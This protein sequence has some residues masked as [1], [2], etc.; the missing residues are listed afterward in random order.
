MPEREPPFEPEISRQVPVDE[1]TASKPEKRLRGEID[2]RFLQDQFNLP[3]EQWDEKFRQ[4]IQEKAE[5]NQRAIEETERELAGEVLETSQE[6]I[7]ESPEVIRE[8]TFERYTNG[9][10]LDGGE[11]IE[12][13]IKENVTQEAYGLD[14][15]PDKLPI[16][17]DLKNHIFEGNFQKELPIKNLDYVVSLGTVSNAIWGGEEVQDIEGIIKNSLAALK[18]GGE[19]RIYPIQEATENS[20]LEGTKE[21]HKKWIH[22]LEKISKTEGVEYSINPRTVK[23]VGKNNDI[24][25]ESVL[26]IKNELGK[27]AKW[28]KIV[29]DI[30]STTDGLGK[31]IEKDIKDTVIGLNALGIGTYQS[32]HGHVN[33][34]R[35]SPWVAINA[36][37]APEPRFLPREEIT[38]GVYEKYGISENLWK[39]QEAVTGEW[40]QEEAKLQ[41]LGDSEYRKAVDELRE[42]LFKKHGFTEDDVEKFNQLSKDHDLKET[43]EYEA[44]SE[45]NKKLHARVGKLLEEFYKEREVPENVRILLAEYFEGN[46]FNIYSGKEDYG[47]E[48]RKKISDKEKRELTKRLKLY[49]AEFKEFAEF[50][51]DKFFES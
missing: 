23:V 40:K 22:L 27:E 11:F 26:V 13:L 2:P 8:R 47:K 28:H 41:K 36:P 50:L 16:K 34:G 32:C 21:S 42:K 12:H 51:K 3:K 24:I 6:K 1:P 45:E 46:H 30:E 17:E 9:L 10:G 7:K 4:M 19:M 35:I 25:L 48:P 39:K 44:W 37:N 31:K 38:K 5:E 18:E 14:A 15:N 20:D 33:R 49:R 29:E 43:P